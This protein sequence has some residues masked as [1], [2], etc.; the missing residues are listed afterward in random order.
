M[1]ISDSACVQ[2]RDNAAHITSVVKF[3]FGARLV[4]TDY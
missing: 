2:R 3:V 4:E 1:S